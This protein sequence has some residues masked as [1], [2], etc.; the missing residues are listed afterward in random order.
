M[1]NVNGRLLE[2]NDRQ[3][4]LHNKIKEVMT[5]QTKVVVLVDPEGEEQ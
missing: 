1:I 4:L 2:I 3:I 5:V